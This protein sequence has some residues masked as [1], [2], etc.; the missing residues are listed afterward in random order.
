MQAEVT[1][2]V[3]KDVSKSFTSQDLD[4]QKDL[5]DKR[6]QLLGLTY[7]NLGCVERQ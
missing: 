4:F 1:L 3:V 7:N 5:K 2:K 6:N